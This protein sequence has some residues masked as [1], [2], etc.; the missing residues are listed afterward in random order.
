MT[1]KDAFLDASNPELS[2]SEPANRSLP[3]DCIQQ[4]VMQ[5]LD[6][7]ACYGS[8]R[9]YLSISP[10]LAEILGC[11]P[12]SL[13]HQTQADLLRRSDQSMALCT[14]WQA[15]D[16]ALIAVLQQG[17]SQRR[18]HHGP[19]GAPGQ[20]YET[21]YTPLRDA[22]GQ[23]GYILSI[24]HEASSQTELQAFSE[25]RPVSLQLAPNSASDSTSVPI[26][27]AE[28]P[29][30]ERPKPPRRSVD[31]KQTFWHFKAPAQGER[32]IVAAAGSVHETTE[33]LKLVLDNI[34]QYIFWKDRNSVYLGCNR[35]WADMAGIG[36]PSNVVGL[37]DDD[38]P[39]TEAQRDWYLECDRRV[40]D[41][42][43][44]MLR[45][46]QSQRQ[47][48]GQISWRETSKL[49][50]HDADGNVIGLLG[51]I[52][53]IT[54]RKLAEDLMARSRETFEQLAKQRELLNQISTQIRRSLQPEVIQQTTVHEIRQ[55]LN[56]DRVVIYRFEENW[57]GQVI[58]ESVVP[59]WC[60]TLGDLGSD[61][62]FIEAYAGLYRQGR[63]GVISDVQTDC[64][65]PCHRD[66]LQRLAVQANLIVPILVQDD[67]W[68]LLIAHQ[69]AAP[70]QWQASEIELLQALA[71]QFGV[72]IQQGELHAQTQRSAA[73]AQQQAQQLE[74]ALKDLKQAQS[75]LIQTEKMS[76]LG[77]MVGGIAHEINNPTAFIYGNVIH[78]KNYYRSLS[79]LVAL[80]QQHYPTPPPAIVQHIETIELDYLLED[81]EQALESIK[82]GSTRI[83]DIVT[84]LRRFSHLDEAGKKAV[85]IHEGLDS[86]L[87]I[88]QP[89]LKAIS[90]RA[91]IELIKEYGYLPLVECY[92][93]QLNQVFMNL[94]DNAIDALKQQIEA[95][96]RT[97]LDGPPHIKISTQADDDQAMITISNNGPGI[98]EAD[99]ERL[100]DPFFTT[101]PI[102][103]G[104]GLGLSISHQIVTER[105]GGSLT[106][107][108]T[109]ENGTEFRVAIPLN[110]HD[111]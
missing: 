41:T 23:I 14:Y 89:H 98:P 103:K 91:E 94:I 12:E 66:F 59:P 47:A 76:S 79:A 2:K 62:C 86:T 77:R 92:P 73:L 22:S 49:P 30:P 107:L 67:L 45:I 54:E 61:N 50:L 101:K 11:K 44:P 111:P 55:L 13:L 69:C 28:M 80:Y 5:S 9:R 7:M 25:S 96:E 20:R 87:L 95:G 81:I 48:D 33:F 64:V 106:V 1:V 99:Q 100:F 105:H 21:T 102:G 46:K 104:K 38:L 90:H 29:E 52:E 40:I 108:S 88:L 19:T 70:R 8:D 78:L 51:T 71:G 57:H 93:S 31:L 24:S 37:T 42:N 15:V 3:L 68:G 83:R 72:A 17:T 16:E 109:P 65:D 53:D 75:Q 85:D 110:Q 36:D 43:T 39:W 63:V 26:I 56:A 60:S 10:R 6:A 27:A 74:V 32:T 35:G 4:W 34:P 84:S 82:V 18:I 97:P 58:V